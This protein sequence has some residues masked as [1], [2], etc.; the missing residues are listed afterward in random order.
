[1]HSWGRTDSPDNSVYLKDNGNLIRCEK[2][3]S[4]VAMH[5]GGEGGWDSGVRELRRGQTLPLTLYSVGG[6]QVNIPPPVALD[7]ARVIA[8]PIATYVPFTLPPGLSH[9][10]RVASAFV[11]VLG[12]IP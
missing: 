9:E 6:I 12:G 2:F 7:A 4:D 10:D 1:V 5:A 3:D 11:R 8:F